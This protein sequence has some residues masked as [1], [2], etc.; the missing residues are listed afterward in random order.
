MLRNL[1]GVKEEQKEEQKQELTAAQLRQ[2][3]IQNKQQQIKSMLDAQQAEIETLKK[4][5]AAQSLP[6]VT[7]MTETE[8]NKA[9]LEAEKTAEQAKDQQRRSAILEQH[10]K[11]VKD[12]GRSNQKHYQSLQDGERIPVLGFA[13]YAPYSVSTSLYGAKSRVPALNN[14]GDRIP[15]CYATSPHVPKQYSAVVAAAISAK[16]SHRR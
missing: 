11:N 2:Q 10:K 1:F 4:K 8:A 16:P 6:V 9:K 14:K 3:A 13:P 12:N 5:K 15:N 7:V